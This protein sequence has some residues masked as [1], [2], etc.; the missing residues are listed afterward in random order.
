M[1]NRKIPSSQPVIA[2]GS[3]TYPLRVAYDAQAVVAPEQ[4][5]GKGAHLRNLLGPHI[6]H[7]VG[8]APGGSQ[9]T[10]LPIIQ[11]G[12]SDYLVWQQCSLPRLL[13]SQKPDVFVAPFNIAPLLIP[14]RTKL[15]VVVHDLISFE[16]YPNVGLR[17]RLQLR[18]WSALISASVRRAF[19]V[20]T[21]SE[22]SRQQILRRFPRARVAVL[23]NTIAESWFL[24][25][26]AIPA[27]NR[28]NYILMVTAASPHK[29][30]DRALQAYAG[31]VRAAAAAPADLRIVGISK[32]NAAHQETR[33]RELGIQERVRFMP[34]LLEIE[35]QEL[36]RRANALFIPSLMEGF[37]IPVLESM[38]SGTPVISSS[39][40]SLPEVGGTAPEY[41]DPHDVMDM[42]RVLSSVVTDSNLRA[43]MAERGLSRARTFHPLVVREQIDRFWTELAQL[44]SA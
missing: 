29:N 38:A 8:L 18:Y 32:T 2:P 5:I 37:G 3:E 43:S 25:D 16:K 30:L 33:L 35:L 15:L 6:Q 40:T 36:Y 10:T 7:F 27:Q 39:T 9:K 42:C 41:C 11:A 23:P 34:Y 24:G 21:V 44:L 31:Y 28:D 13:F 17:F 22:F 26:K 12:F 1:T 19:M 14:K 4:H 20:I